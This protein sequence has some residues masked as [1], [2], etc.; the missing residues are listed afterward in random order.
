MEA[1]VARD[2]RKS[3]GPVEAVAGV[4]LSVASGEVVAVLGPNGAGKTT[5][6]EMLLGLRKPTG[7]SIQVFGEAPDHRAV[8]GRI[9]AMLQDTDAPPGWTV[10]EMVSLVGRYYPYSLPVDDV[11]ARADLTSQRGARVAALSGGQRQRLS[12]AVAIAGDPDLLFL[13]EPTAALDVEARRAFWHQVRGFA[14]LGKTVLFSTHNLAE[15]DAIANRIVVIH[16]GRVISDGAPAEIKALVGGKT[17]RLVTDASPDD[18]RRIECVGRVDLDP[19]AA[20]PGGRVRLTIQTTVP[21]QLIADLF[22]AGRTVE[23]LTVVD[24]DLET[25]FLRLTGRETPQESAA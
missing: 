13:D 12:F 19:V 5:T 22:A 6:I 21:E 10:S 18:V 9:G 4:D 15:A 20:A 3:Y 1:V 11:L 17:V 2:L 24:T 25:A 14:D 8:R 23:D 16:R 7:G